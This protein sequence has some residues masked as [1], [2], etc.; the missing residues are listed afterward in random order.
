[1]RRDVLVIAHQYLP[2]DPRVG[3]SIAA[4]DQAGAAVDV[5][6]LR[7]SGQPFRGRM[8]RARLYRLPVRRHRGAGLLTYIAEYAAF[9]VL[10]SFAAAWLHVRRRYRVVVTHTLPDPLVFAA[11][12]P[13]LLGARIVMDMHEFTPELYETRYRLDR[14]HRLIRAMLALERWSCRFAN[15]VVTVHDPGVDILARTGI[16]RERIVVVMNSADPSPGRDR[17]REWEREP[18]GEARR[19]FTLIY[20]GTLVNQYDLDT[21]VRALALLAEQGEHGFVLRVVGEGP[22][23][24]GLRELAAELGVE[25]RV[26]FEPPVPL[27]RVPD[28]LARCDAGLVPMLDVRYAHVALPMKVLECMAAGLPVI[29]NPTAVLTHYFDDSSVCMVRF[30]DAGALAGAMR[31]VRDDAKYRRELVRNA[32]EAL[33]PIR[34]EVMARR[35]AEACGLVVAAPETAAAAEARPT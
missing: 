17:E 1:M 29:S 19:P 12:V 23:L 28:I 9:F 3:K 11:A 31:R 24:G 35:F 13:R 2:S 21:G 33:H 5:L 26:R 14:R 15:T 22:G 16:P 20:H 25:D 8:G 4:L 32:D 30:G 10:A 6:C 34:W 7:E 27:A 18:D